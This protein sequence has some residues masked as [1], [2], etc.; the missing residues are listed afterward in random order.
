MLW[1]NRL[2]VQKTADVNEKIEDIAKVAIKD[3]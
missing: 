3:G 2:L 1:L